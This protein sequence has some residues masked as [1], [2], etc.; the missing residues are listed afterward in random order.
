MI[1]QH[2]SLCLFVYM[3][4]TLVHPAKA[5]GWNEMPFGRDTHLA[6]SNIILDRGPDP[7]MKNGGIG[8]KKPIFGHKLFDR[9][10]FIMFIVDDHL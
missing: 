8:G 2:G 1:P 7:P 5:T 6:T 9:K 10:C 4:V 3:S